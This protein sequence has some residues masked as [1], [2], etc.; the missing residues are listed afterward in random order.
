M[1]PEVV[2][3]RDGNAVTLR[4]CPPW[5]TGERHFTEDDVIYPD[6]GYHH[7][8][9]EAEVPTSS[10]FL[11]MADGARTVIR[12]VLK[13]WT[14]PLDADPGPALIELNLG[15]A[16]TGTDMCA[17]FTPAQARAVAAALLDR[18]ATAEQAGGD[19]TR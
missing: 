5:C 1:M 4:P 13:S 8:G 2:Y 7:Y 10:S 14:C 11:G 6:D 3:P 18:A 17:E 12:V 15:T 9:P 19:R 16:D